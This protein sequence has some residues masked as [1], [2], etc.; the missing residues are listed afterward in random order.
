MRKVIRKRAKDVSTSFGKQ[1]NLR[2]RQLLLCL[3]KDLHIPGS[4]RLEQPDVMFAR[5]SRARTLVLLLLGVV[6]GG[7]SLRVDPRIVS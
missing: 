7:E 3:H 5:S 6:L 4:E 1:K 2:L